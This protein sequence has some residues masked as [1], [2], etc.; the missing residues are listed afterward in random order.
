MIKAFEELRVQAE[1]SRLEK[2]YKLKEAADKIEQL[3]KRHK[4]EIN[5][6]EKQISILTEENGEKDNKMKQISSQ[7]Q[8]SRLLI[9]EFEEIRKQQDEILKKAE[10]KQQNSLIE[11]ENTIHSLKDTKN[12]CKNLETELQIIVKTLAEVTE[13]KELIIRELE[14]TRVLHTSVIDG[15]QIEISNLKEML[16]K[17][18]K[19][20]KELRDVSDALVL[21]LQNKSTE[22]EMMTKLKNDKE[23]R[24]EELEPVLEQVQEFLHGKQILEKTNEKLQER[25]REL[26]DTLQ[27]KEKEIHDLEMQLSDEF[28]NKQNCFQQLTTLKAELEK[29]ILKN[30]QLSME[31]N[32]LLFEKEQ[33]I[34]E[35]KTV[36]NELQKCKDNIKNNK[37]IDEEAKNQ[38]E[39]LKQNNLLL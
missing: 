23:K 35:K 17:E 39:I 36:D 26:K 10:S 20:Q 27:T 4:R 5:A 30:E 8:E 6:M 18:E 7:L 31:W 15:F 16:M 3:E 12:T 34:T 33:I 19:R 25:E 1:N 2:Y 28:E 38:I 9:L 13:Q 22:L 21:E 11:L 32:K 14:E 37:N 29:E 24:I